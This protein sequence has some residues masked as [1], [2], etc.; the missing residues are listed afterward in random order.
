MSLARLLTTTPLP[1]NRRIAIVALASLVAAGLC[2][3]GILTLAWLAPEGEPIHSHVLAKVMNDSSRPWLWRESHLESH[4]D[5]PLA[6]RLAI[7]DLFFPLL[8]GFGFL[9]AYRTLTLG[10]PSH[11]LR[12]PRQEKMFFAPLIGGM[13]FDWIE[14][15]L[16]LFLH[17]DA[18]VGNPM[19][20]GIIATAAMATLLK[21]AMIAFVAIQLGARAVYVLF[22]GRQLPAARDATLEPG[23]LSPSRTTG[24]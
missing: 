3:A 14:N 2:F 7:C 23:D 24:R 6:L 4:F 12:K 8:Y 22:F 11:V 21:T 20:S 9:V 10:D 15:L 17:Q 16:L 18:A 13:A 5:N 19:P 1:L